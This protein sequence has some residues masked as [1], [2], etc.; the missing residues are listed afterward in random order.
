MASKG[1]DLS[2]SRKSY[3]LTSDEK[4][5]ATGEAGGWEGLP[6]LRK[7]GRGR[8]VQG[9]GP[10]GQLLHQLPRGRAPTGPLLTPGAAE[11]AVALTRALPPAH[12]PGIVHEKLLEDYLHRVFSPDHAAAAAS[13]YGLR[14]ASSVCRASPQAGGR[15]RLGVP[16]RPLHAGPHCVLPS[17]ELGGQ[18]RRPVSA[19]RGTCRLPPTWPSV[20]RPASDRF[21]PHRPSP[22]KFNAFKFSPRQSQCVFAGA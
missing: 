11:L 12:G 20:A 22:C 10:C 16:S 17:R 3:G 1:A 9:P 13:R 14:A 5:R 15:T 19:Q 8:G 4:P 6:E 18:R 2:F 7:G 21:T